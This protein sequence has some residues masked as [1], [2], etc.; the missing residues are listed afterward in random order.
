MENI[1]EDDVSIQEM[2][3]LEPNYEV[4]MKWTQPTTLWE[5]IL[6]KRIKLANV[7]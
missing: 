4:F 3:L 6:Q 5:T 7:R 2:E 1:Y